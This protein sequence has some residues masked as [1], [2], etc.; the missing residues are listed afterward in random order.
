MAYFLMRQMP[1]KLQ[2]KFLLNFP[3]KFHLFKNIGM[4]KGKFAFVNT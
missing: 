4:N 2:L 1:S 3:S